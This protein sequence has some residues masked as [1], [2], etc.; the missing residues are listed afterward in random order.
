MTQSSDDSGVRYLPLII[1]G[2]Y[3]QCHQFSTDWALVVDTINAGH[4]ITST[5]STNFTNFSP[6]WEVVECEGGW[7]YQLEGHHVSITVEQD[8]VCDRAWIP[9]LSQSLFFSGAIPGMIFFGWFADAYG[10]IPA[11]MASN[12]ICLITGVATPF[13]QEYISFL[14]LRF[15]MGLAFNTFFTMP[16]VL[17]RITRTES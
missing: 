7:E 11:I 2:G 12:I 6:D 17:G 10:R 1:L 16:Y 15:L 5:T 13:A 8:W 14:V 9:A 3:S 4:N